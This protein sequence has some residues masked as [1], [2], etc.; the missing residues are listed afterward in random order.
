[1]FVREISRSRAETTGWTVSGGDASRQPYRE[2]EDTP[3]TSHQNREWS[4]FHVTILM[5]CFW[6][7]VTWKILQK[8]VIKIGYA[9]SSG[10]A[11]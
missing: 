4:I 10:R 1:L 2:V 7:I 8:Q 6:R 11:A 3:K 5:S 9:Y